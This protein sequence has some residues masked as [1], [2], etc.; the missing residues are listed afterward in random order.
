MTYYILSYSNFWDQLK[1][2]ESQ[3]LKH[4]F[5][6]FGL[7]SP[8]PPPIFILSLLNSEINIKTGN[9]FICSCVRQTTI[10]TVVALKWKSR[11]RNFAHNSEQTGKIVYTHVR[12]CFPIFRI[13]KWDARGLN[14]LNAPI[15]KWLERRSSNAAVV[16]LSPGRGRTYMCLPCWGQRTSW[17]IKAMP[18]MIFFFFFFFFLVNMLHVCTFVIFNWTVK[19][20]TRGPWPQRSWIYNYVL[21]ENQASVLPWKPRTVIWTKSTWEE[22]DYSRCFWKLF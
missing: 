1:T 6:V 2:H 9:F 11:P 18:G 22:E 17:E 15:A 14:I 21:L 16:R 7:V 20:Q 8:I 4:M 3:A 12:P 10:D 5:S 13:I 19:L